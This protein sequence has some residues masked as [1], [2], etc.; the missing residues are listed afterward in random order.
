ML[1]RLLLAALLVTVLQAAGKSLAWA[2]GQCPEGATAA[3]TNMGVICVAAQDPGTPGTPEERPSDSGG[4]VGCYR[5]DGKRVPCDTGL[6]TWFP[7]S[8]CYAAP[9]DAPPGSAAWQGQSDGSLWLCT[10]CPD[11]SANTCNAQ[12]IWLPPGTSPGPPD[13]GVLAQ[14][15]TG[16]LRLATAQVHTAP[17]HPARSYVGVENWLW[18]PESQWATLTKTVTAGGTSVTVTAEPERVMWEMGPETQTCYA[19]GREWRSGMGDA[20]TTT[21][22]YTYRATSA[23][24][25]D[26][27]F[28]IAATIRYRV[29]WVCAGACPR[30]S[31]TL[32]LVD[33]P[34]GTGVL[35]VLQRQTVVIQ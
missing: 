24:E 8:Q 7:G 18:V 4:P 33:A 5:D 11:G 12:T 16:T 26:G 22:G 29:E 34:A 30:G 15:A 6:G 17:Q 28:A 13:P 21:C 2:E 3:Q 35:R 31:G 1:S 25:P 10:T 14:Q 27:V 20:A 23:S 9:Y 19:A 32:G